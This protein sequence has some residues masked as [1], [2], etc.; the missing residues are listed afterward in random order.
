MNE[1]VKTLIGWWNL[2]GKSTTAREPFIKFFIYYICLDAWLTAESGKEK[3]EE[4]L[5]WFLN[6]DNCL[7]AVT[8]DFWES[9]AKRF[10]I[11]L[12]N[13]SPIEDVRPNHRGRYIHLNDININNLEE[14]LRFIYQIRCN[15]FHGQKSPKN[16][17]D[18][19][20][21]TSS[22]GFLEEWIRWACRK[23]LKKL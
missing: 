1:N 11:S 6:N 14:I 12:K 21:I 5:Q 10:L 19:T 18:V 17:R 3:F 23:C 16:S 7:K 8:K 20:L 4:K 2:K 9:R 13:N 15:F 22:A